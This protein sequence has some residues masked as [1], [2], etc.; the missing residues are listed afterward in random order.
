MADILVLDVVSCGSSCTVRQQNA[1]KN[2][3]QNT[4]QSV[5]RE[6]SHTYS[7]I[8]ITNMNAYMT[9]NL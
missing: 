4:E 6:D 8:S 7:C 1:P 5:T 3:P 2:Q 9:C